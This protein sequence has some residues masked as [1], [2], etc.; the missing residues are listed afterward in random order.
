MLI[1]VGCVISK[2]V[3]SYYSQMVVKGEFQY[4]DNL[5]LCQLRSATDDDL[6]KLYLLGE[7]RENI[8]HNGGVSNFQMM[9]Q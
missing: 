4:G 5:A 1:G 7:M 9:E 8:S 6:Q 2:T 3:E